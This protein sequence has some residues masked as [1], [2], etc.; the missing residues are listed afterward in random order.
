MDALLEFYRCL[1][2]TVLSSEIFNFQG[3][4][5]LISCLPCT[6]FAAT[7]FT[8][9]WS[10]LALSS[11]SSWSS[12][13]L[14]CP[15]TSERISMF[16][17]TPQMA[18]SFQTSIQWLLLET[19]QRSAGFVPKWSW[20]WTWFLWQSFFPSIWPFFSLPSSLLSNLPHTGS[21]LNLNGLYFNL[22]IFQEWATVHQVG[23][24][25]PEQHCPLLHTWPWHWHWLRC[26]IFSFHVWKRG[27]RNSFHNCQWPCR[28]F[29]PLYIC[30]RQNI[31]LGAVVTST[32]LC[33]KEIYPRKIHQM[34]FVR[35]FFSFHSCIL[36][37]CIP[38][39]DLLCRELYRKTCIWA[40]YSLCTRQTCSSPDVIQL[41]V[42]SECCLNQNS[43]N[44]VFK[45]HCSNDLGQIVL[46]KHLKG[47]LKLWFREWVTG[48]S[49]KAF[50]FVQKAPRSIKSSG[51]TLLRPT[52]TRVQW[53]EVQHGQQ[54]KHPPFGKV[55]DDFG[56]F[57]H[58]KG[59]F[60]IIAWA[61]PMF[62]AWWCVPNICHGDYIRTPIY[63]ILSLLSED[64]I[65]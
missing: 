48:F 2:L 39:S 57:L 27:S 46:I 23:Q 1:S 43:E 25:N 65:I 58:Q 29:N 42:I 47:R 17:R 8:L 52:C 33:A 12:S 44:F 3:W 9:S 37:V 53:P 50:K 63:F 45:L 40:S 55:L 38:P 18:S 59:P 32:K 11:P 5:Q 56:H 61:L 31:F 14:V 13:P 20:S 35:I 7:A 6:V 4:R 24:C 21:C 54:K 34:W 64:V 41:D 10:S 26:W 28:N 62:S 36:V 15:S 19:W 49:A 30:Q 16:E 22:K 60:C 51:N